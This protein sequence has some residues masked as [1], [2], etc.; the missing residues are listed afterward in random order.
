M[1]VVTTLRC[2]VQIMWT[3][4]TVKQRDGVVYFG[5]TKIGRSKSP[6]SNRES[7]REHWWG[8]PH[9]CSLG[10]AACHLLFMLT[11]AILMPSLFH[12]PVYSR[13]T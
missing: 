10:A 6:F 1:G 3:V 13:A 7:A 4:D 11:R 8:V 9:Q 5:F 12:R 2:T